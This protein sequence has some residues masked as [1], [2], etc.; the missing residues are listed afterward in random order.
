MNIINSKSLLNY[1]TFKIDA[2]ADLFTEI[3]SQKDIIE[4]L[5]N[6][7]LHKKE[8]LIRKRM[9]FINYLISLWLMLNN[10]KNFLV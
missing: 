9:S 7:S 2:Y 3:K 5:K 10:L 4:I 8:I 6:E 1:N